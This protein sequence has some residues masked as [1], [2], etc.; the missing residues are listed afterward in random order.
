MTFSFSCPSSWPAPSVASRCSGNGPHVPWRPCKG[1][2]VVMTNSLGALEANA[3]L[4]GLADLSE[5]GLRRIPDKREDDRW[6]HWSL[7]N[8][9]PPRFPLPLAP[10]CLATSD[11]HIPIPHRLFHLVPSDA[12]LNPPGRPKGPTQKEGLAFSRPGGV[13]VD[14]DHAR[15]R[16]RGQRHVAWANSWLAREP[17]FRRY[18]RFLERS[19][20][21]STSAPRHSIS[22]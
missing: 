18:F 20:A 6:S 17:R 22:R 11:C 15:M 21:K 12:I 19:T 2:Y 10:L 8:P 16:V 13:F 14:Y 9:L 5:R 7:G 3:S 4:G 1:A